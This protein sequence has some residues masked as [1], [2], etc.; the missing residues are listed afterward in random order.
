MAEAP[1]LG[2]EGVP[3]PGEGWQ[4]WAALAAQLEEARLL[5]MGRAAGG[6]AVRGSAGG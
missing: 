5:G 2:L 4:A 3:G 1:R 6:L